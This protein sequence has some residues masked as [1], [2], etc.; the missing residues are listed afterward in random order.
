MSL[1]RSPPNTDRVPANNS[2]TTMTVNRQLRP[3]LGKCGIRLSDPNEQDGEQKAPR[4]QEPRD[5]SRLWIEE[6]LLLQGESSRWSNHGSGKGETSDLP[7][8]FGFS[9]DK[10]HH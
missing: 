9:F 7:L 8:G 4:L 1:V 3:L 5:L 2:A 10:C 6:L